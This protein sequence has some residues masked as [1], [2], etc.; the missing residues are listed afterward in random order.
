MYRLMEEDLDEISQ[1]DEHEEIDQ[2]AADLLV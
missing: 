1:E 2:N